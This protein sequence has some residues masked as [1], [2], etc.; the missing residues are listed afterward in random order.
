MTNKTN[1]IYSF[2]QDIIPKKRVE[3]ENLYNEFAEQYSIE[4]NKGDLIVA[5]NFNRPGIEISPNQT[6][7]KILSIIASKPFSEL[8]IKLSENY[9]NSGFSIFETKNLKFIQ[10]NYK[11][12]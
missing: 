9:L 3:L 2:R 1:V 10:V 11:K 7:G 8:E 4:V 6:E 12:Q 5:Q